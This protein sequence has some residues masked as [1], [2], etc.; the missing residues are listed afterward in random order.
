MI[1][2]NLRYL[3]KQ[4]LSLIL[5][6]SFFFTSCQQSNVNIDSKNKI[7][8]QI[9]SINEFELLD[10]NDQSIPPRITKHTEYYNNGKIKYTETFG[11]GELPHLI[12]RFDREGNLLSEVNI[13][14]DGK[15]FMKVDYEYDSY[16]NLITYKSFNGKSQGIRFGSSITTGEKYEIKYREDQQVNEELVFDLAG[17]YKRKKTYNY[18]NNLL[19]SVKSYSSKNILLNQTDYDENG[20]EIKRSSFLGGNQTVSYTY[21]FDDNNNMV[22][23][24]NNLFRKVVTYNQKGLVEQQDMLSTTISRRIS[25]IYNEK[26]QA[27]EEIFSIQ[28]GNKIGTKDWDLNSK[29]QNTYDE[30]GNITL[31]L[32]TL[33]D[34]STNTYSFKYKY[35]SNANWLEKVEYK[36]GKPTL[37][38]TRDYTYY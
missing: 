25:Y 4:G 12:K 28:E 18:K 11:G 13:D 38:R 1:M 7:S 21:K 17:N 19:T 26:G 15:I 3:L 20:N 29:N 37:F 35:D 5:I 33:N 6:T 31:S 30:N 8:I 36:N 14:S 34:N 23:E 32:T 22:F 2:S 10:D 27:V 9:K 24:E 16:F